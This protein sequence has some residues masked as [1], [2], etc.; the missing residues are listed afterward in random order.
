VGQALFCAR[1]Y[2][3]A[4]RLV[5]AIVLGCLFVVL[6]AVQV[7]S[8]IA[9]RASAQ[10]GSW[11][12]LVP[13]GVADRVD[14]VDAKFP[15]PP[16]LRLVLA[17]GALA[18]GDL[19]LA[20]RD[21]GALAPSRDRLALE[22][23]LA[24]ARGDSAG[25][26]RDYLAAGDLAGIQAH[27]D[28]LARGGR[29]ADAIVLERELVARLGSDRAQIDALAQAWFELGLIEQARAYQLAASKTADPAAHERAS[30]DAYAHAVSLAPFD[31]RYLIAFANEQLNLGNLKAAVGGFER[32]RDAD[33]TSAE[34]ISGLGDAAF[35]RG[36]RAAALG[37]L[38]RARALDP[39]SA[40][41]ASLAAKLG[42]P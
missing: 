13:E 3:A 5:A 41:V 35:R 9:L 15:V 34:P 32:A 24:A 33:P 1:P 37:F 2:V 29:V 7:L 16:A 12:G 42:R 20:A 30:A 22:A 6:G 14:R 18:R 17:R 28:D 38:G 8:S 25:A 40:A 27:I 19:A 26:V 23:G 39:S 11:V 4:M 21:T 10:P 36:D 31:E